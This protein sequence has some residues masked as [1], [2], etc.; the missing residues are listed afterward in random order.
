MLLWQQHY[1]LFHA[2]GWDFGR[3]W[4]EARD[5]F[6]RLQLRIQRVSQH[7]GSTDPLEELRLD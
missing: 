4:K 2:A 6:A 5:Q 1:K 3:F 7:V